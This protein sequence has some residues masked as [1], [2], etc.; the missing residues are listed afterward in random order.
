LH[1]AGHP[2]L[3]LAQDRTEMTMPN[4]R[5]ASIVVALLA[6]GAATTSPMAQTPAPSTPTSSKITG[7][8]QKVESVPNKVGSRCGNHLELTVLA[9]G[10]TAL[11]LYIYDRTVRSSSLKDL[12]GK[13]VE[14]DLVGETI[15]KTI[16]VADRMDA[17]VAALDNLSTRKLC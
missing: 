15:V 6:L 10:G 8:L 1:H 4:A 3:G 14:I 11:V 17:T 7:T 12:D 13:K 9:D 16:R 2:D 5:I